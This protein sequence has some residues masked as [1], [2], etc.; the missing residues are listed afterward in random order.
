MREVASCIAEVLRSVK[1]ETSEAAIAGVRTRVEALTARFPLYAWRRDKVAGAVDNVSDKV[2]G[3][4]DDVSRNEVAA[5][6]NAN[7]T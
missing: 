5:V 3:V 2:A 6:G 4:V 7:R 1:S